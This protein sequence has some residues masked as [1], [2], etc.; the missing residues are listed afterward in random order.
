MVYGKQTERSEA[1]SA[2][3]NPET[4]SPLMNYFNAKKENIYASKSKEPLGKTV[5]RTYQ[6]P[7]FVNSEQFRFGHSVIPDVSSKEL[8]FP[9]GDIYHVDD[10][11]HDLYVQTHKSYHPG[12]QVRRYKEGIPL[13]TTEHRFGKVDN[14]ELDGVKK[15]L[16]PSV[17]DK[18]S[19]FNYEPAIVNKTQ[20]EYLQFHRDPLGKSRHHILTQNDLP[21]HVLESAHTFGMA[22]KADP[23]GASECM[24]GNYT[25]EQQ[26]PDNDLGR[27]VKTFRTTLPPN[28]PGR[29]YGCPTIRYDIKAPRNR[30]ISDMSNYG[31]EPNAHTTMYPSKYSRI[32]E[33]DFDT[34]VSRQTIREIIM[35]SGCIDSDQE[36]DK[37]YDYALHVYE[38]DI[39]LLKRRDRNVSR[40]L[41]GQD[42]VDCMTVDLFRQA[43]A[44]FTID[45]H[46]HELEQQLNQL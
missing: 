21:Q 4:E 22:T 35:S 36:F 37:V 31:N 33:E 32:T 24:K 44:K 17:T 43:L 9:R 39:D 38:H 8:I 5:N 41:I 10:S 28:D 45:H 34:L 42:A 30:S 12:E 25:S 40:P 13:D 19:G 15:S 1:A 23:W 18:Q 16:Q 27:T 2:L 3:V 11:A 26:Q 6:L 20:Q 7:D 29:I 14:K 46:Q